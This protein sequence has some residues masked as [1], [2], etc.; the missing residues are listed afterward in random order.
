MDF[1][2]QNVRTIFAIYLLPFQLPFTIIIAV[3]TLLVTIELIYSMQQ[4]DQV[5]SALHIYVLEVHGE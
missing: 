3:K 2:S 4:Q 1:T 5:T